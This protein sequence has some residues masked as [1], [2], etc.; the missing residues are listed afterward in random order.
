MLMPTILVNAAIVPSLVPMTAWFVTF[1]W[2]ALSCSSECVVILG[3]TVI[4]V[5]LAAVASASNVATTDLMVAT[6]V[7]LTVISALVYSSST[8]MPFPRP[9]GLN[10]L[11]KTCLNP[12]IRITMSL[13][14][15]WPCPFVKRMSFCNL[16]F[17]LVA[18]GQSSREACLGHGLSDVWLPKLQPL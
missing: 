4:V 8:T 5:V 12:L 3:G 14:W 2:W 15:Y 13:C 9:P 1:R 16:L 10:A 17:D 18:R 6:S 7:D 11:F